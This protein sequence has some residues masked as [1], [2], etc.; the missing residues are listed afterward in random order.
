MEKDSKKVKGGQRDRKV[1]EPFAERHP[2]AEMHKAYLRH[3]GKN[4]QPVT[5]Y[6]HPREEQHRLAVSLE[7]P[8]RALLAP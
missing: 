2:E 6:R 5:E 1:A 8:G 3:P 7:H 4:D